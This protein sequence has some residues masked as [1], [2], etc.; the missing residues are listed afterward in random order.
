[1]QVAMRCGYN[2]GRGDT[3]A[4]HTFVRHS[5]K[6]AEKSGTDRPLTDLESRTWEVTTDF[7][8]SS[9][10]PKISTM[11]EWVKL[12]IG[13]SHFLTTKT[14][15]CREKGTFLARLVQDDPDLPSLKVL[16]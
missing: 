13:G 16:S 5:V 12:N 15:L 7:H 2:K 6:M 14:T 4:R 11:D 8:S 10:S 1:M 3:R 9:L